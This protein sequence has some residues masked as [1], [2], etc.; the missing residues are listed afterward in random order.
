MICRNIYTIILGKLLSKFPNLS[1]SVVINPFLISPGFPNC[2]SCKLCNSK[3]KIF[4]V[5][6]RNGWHE[7][8]S[9]HAITLVYLLT[10][11]TRQSD[12]RPLSKRTTKRLKLIRLKT[13]YWPVDNEQLCYDLLTFNILNEVAVDLACGYRCYKLV[14]T[15]LFENRN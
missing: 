9:P 14:L 2:P 1:H 4:P 6:I 12:W 15:K 11:I 7:K 5:E 8:N 10:I 3:K 13:H